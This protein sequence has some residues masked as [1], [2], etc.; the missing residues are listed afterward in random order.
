MSVSAAYGSWVSPLTI[1][2]LTG[3]GV[4]LDAVSSDGGSVYWTESR[5]REGGRTVVV[6]RDEHG[7]ISDAVPPGFNARSRAHEYGGGAYAVRD[8]LLIASRFEDQRVY[9]FDGEESVPITPEPKR[10]AGDR[11]ADFVFQGDR[12]ICVREHHRREKEPANSLV[13]FPLDGSD[14][15]RVI[16][17]G[18][19]FYSSPRISPDGQRIAWLEWNHPQM[20]WDGTEL[21]CGALD[22]D[23]TI[24]EPELV[25]GGT[26]ESIFQP[27]WSPRGVLHF[28]SDR[29]GWWN[30]FRQTDRGIEAL[31]L[32]EAELGLPQWVFG[33]SRYGFLLERRVV[34]TYTENGLDRLG[35]IEGGTLQRVRVPYEQFG[36]QVA[37]C[38]DSVYLTAGGP[39]DPM[40]V[41]AVDTATEAVEVIRSSVSMDLDPELVSH[42]EPIEF[43]T[44]GGAEAYAFYYPPRNPA[45]VA[46]EGELPPLLVL[47]HGGPTSATGVDLDLGIQ[48]WTSR[49]FAVVDVNYRGSTGYGRAYR[50]ALRGNWGL[51]DVEDCIN[52]ARYLADEGA[53]DGQRMAIRGGSAGGYTTLCAL[54][55][56]DVFA[57]GASRYGVADCAA[58]AI[59]THKFESRYLDSLIGPYPEA[60][61]VYEARSPLYHT[62][63][64]S[65]PVILLQGLDDRVVPPAQAEQMVAALQ[66]L[67]LPYA[68]LAFEGEGHGFRKAENIERAVG[69]ELY[70]YSRVFGFVPADELEPVDIVNEDAL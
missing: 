29:T 9:R 7:T 40:A 52:A 6:R 16:A 32:M 10:P 20:P 67:G 22:P 59:D 15:P 18:A 57:A 35:V 2:M 5:A 69:A 17:K 30:V 55:F 63:G 24:S 8:G 21:W 3:A 51:A 37:V 44:G 27:D 19:D 23:G 46:L 38:G 61:D 64:F 70:F 65:C 1:S 43:P 13:T 42:P 49:G 58:L 33:L 14:K 36:D 45:Y 60:A 50:N 54:T 26:E 56:F 4:P 39:A 34:V 25:A 47:S 28:V 53:V 68:Y 66:G 11:F 41:V 62:D 12:V 48:F 31:H